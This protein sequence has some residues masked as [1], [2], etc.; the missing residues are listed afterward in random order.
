[1]A[2]VIGVTQMQIENEFYMVDLARMAEIVRKQD[3]LRKLELYNIIHAT[4]LEKE[5]LD[6]LLR[7][8]MDEA[9]IKRK[10]ATFSRSKFE[11][12]RAITENTK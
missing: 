12:L 11:E 5:D 3:A 7:R 9:E 4:R 1:M 8:Y 6:E 10:E 2:G